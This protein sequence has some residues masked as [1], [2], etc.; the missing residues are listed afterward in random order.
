MEDK[1]LTIIGIAAFLLIVIALFGFILSQPSTSSNRQDYW[2]FIFPT[3]PFLI[4]GFCY[5][6]FYY[7]IRW[8]ENSEKERMERERL[9][10]NYK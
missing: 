1:E 9:D 7:G 10:G 5:I 6:A 8:W 4:L 2:R 3:I